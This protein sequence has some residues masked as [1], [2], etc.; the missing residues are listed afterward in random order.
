M[1]VFGTMAARFNDDGVT[2]LYQALL[3]KLN[4]LGLKTAVGKLPKVSVK[5]SSRGRAI[6]PAERVRYLADIADCGARLPPAYRRAGDDCP[7]A[8]EPAHGEGACSRAAAPEPKDFE[9]LIDL[10]GR[11]ARSARE[12]A[13]RD[14]ARHAASV[15]RRRVRREDPRQGSAHR[16]RSTRACPAPGSARWCCRSSRTRVRL[17]RFL[18]KE[19]V[20]GSFPYTAGV[21][22]FKRES[23]D[24]TRMFA[25]EGDAFRTNRRFHYLSEGM[26]AHRLST[27]FDSVTLYGCDPDLRPDIYGKVGN[28]GVS[29]A[30][31]DDMKVLY[32]RLRPG[33]PDHL[34]VDDH[35][36]PGAGDPRHV[37]Q[38]RARP[39]ASTSSAPTTSASRPRTRPTRSANG[40]SRTC[41]APCRPT[42][43]KRTRA[44]TPASSPPS[45]PSR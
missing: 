4:A 21:F 35:Q 8:A 7:R 38:H 25:G 44:R 33:L 26:P 18:M 19:N 36:R 43:S 23:E 14:V 39:A 22:P 16:P 37:L 30:T 27:A 40:C 42:S 11:P 34:G 3:P 41:A 12:E 10:E 1:P 15:L 17:L 29:I 2:A 20:P 32:S 24:P 28:S 6:V 5:Q 31:L 9:E 13:A 45:S